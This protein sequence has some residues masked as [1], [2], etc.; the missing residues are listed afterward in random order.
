MRRRGRQ[1]IAAIIFTWLGIYLLVLFIGTSA[2]VIY[3]C[4][5]N[6]NIPAFAADDAKYYVET[7]TFTLK[8]SFYGNEAFIL[9]N[10]G[11]IICPEDSTHRK[12]AFAGYVDE[13]Y[14]LIAE[15]PE[16]YH[17]FFESL[18]PMNA[19][20]I[21][22][23]AMPD[24]SGH[25]FLI[26]QLR[27][28]TNICTVLFSS[29]T[30]F[31][32]LSC[33]YSVLL[34]RSNRKVEEMRRTYVANVS[35][36]LKSPI[37]SIAA[38]G[39]SLA[40]GVIIG[41]ER[42]KKCYDLI[43]AEAKNLEHTVMDMLELS[44]TQSMEVNF[45]KRCVSASELFLPIV[46]KFSLRCADMGVHFSVPSDVNSLPALY[47]NPERVEV[48]TNVL[49]DNALKFVEPGG[50][51]SLSTEARHKNVV[52]CIRDDGIGIDKSQQKRIFERFYT[53]DHVKNKNGSGL[54]LAI[55][56]EIITVL[57]E[58]IWVESAPGK[59]AAF[60]FTISYV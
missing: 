24:G 53:G 43:V 10:S 47:T 48:L 41:E 23:A 26:R 42:K 39:E 11:E 34:V 37:A 9:T 46:E 45:D 7:G 51:I 25:Y 22:G 6:D 59:G 19:K 52:I 29:M 18:F 50:H 60:F 32:V 33:L 2:S 8:T 14:S 57:G 31:L 27:S 5:S 12:A 1:S 55:A 28:L 35:H 17:F 13:Y 58:K 54:G 49:L 40:D 56:S 44:R 15:N 21:A 38:L 36:E 20:M 3:S 30:I 16:E 4:S